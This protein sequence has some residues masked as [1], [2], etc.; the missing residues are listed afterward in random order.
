MP[1]IKTKRAEIWAAFQ[2]RRRAVPSA[3]FIHGA[4]GS[5]LSFPAALRNLQALEP[6]LVDLPG[7][8]AS[9]GAGRES[10][11]EYALDVLALMDK[12]EIDSAI[13]VGH[14]MGGAIAQHLALE[15]RARVSATVLIATGPRM[16]VNPALIRDIVADTDTTIDRLVRWMWS[17]R[18]AA[19]LIEQSAA[20]L[21]STPASVMQSD[22]I[23]CDN[24]DMSAQL[25]RIAAPT[26]ILAAENDMMT[27]AKLSREL[28]Q[29]IPNSALEILP[30][31]GHMLHL[32]HPNT[33]ANF[34]ARWLANLSL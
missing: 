32:E 24:F 5:H 27:P 13:I 9:K 28:A 14:S 33:T 29:G 31:A 11:A 15:Q 12:C 1:L 21:R 25:Q 17:R 26:L 30:D 23:A 8:G 10:I 2:R 7:H 16:P 34:V 20:I 22:F 3:L 6:I 4:G 18:A 19:E